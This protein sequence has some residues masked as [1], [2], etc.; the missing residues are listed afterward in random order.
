VVDRA[1]NTIF[2]VSLM[3]IGEAQGWPFRI[4]SQSI[5]EFVNLAQKKGVLRTRLGHPGMETDYSQT[6]EQETTIDDDIGSVIG[7]I[8]NIRRFEDRARGDLVLGSYAEVVPEGVGNVKE[9][10]LRLAESDP[11]FFGM[12]AVFKYSVQQQGDEDG[13]YGL[14]VARIESTEAC[15]A[16]GHPAA[17]PNGLLASK[18]LAVPGAQDLDSQRRQEALKS[19]AHSVLRF[20]LTKDTNKISLPAPAPGAASTALVE[21]ANDFQFS[22]DQ[23]KILDAS[24]AALSVLKAYS[25]ALADGH[26]ES[27][28]DQAISTLEGN[29]DHVLEHTADLLERG[30]TS[31]PLPAPADGAGSQTIAPDL[32]PIQTAATAEQSTARLNQGVRVPDFY[33][34]PAERRDQGFIIGR[35]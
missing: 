18:H 5:D 15:D 34:Q 13:A 16:V 23:R 10:L 26:D 7:K 21:Y 25:A 27:S 24:D 35:N 22:D 3:T 28:L 17:N 6:G 19:V 12:S 32:K 11:Q 29:W 9:Y 14:P 20:F 8:V 33:D 30:C 4:D 1:T 2:G 31:I